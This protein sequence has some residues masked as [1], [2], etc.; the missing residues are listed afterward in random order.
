M[1]EILVSALALPRPAVPRGRLRELLR[2]LPGAAAGLAA[3][4]L[5]V[6]LAFCL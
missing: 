4:F 3:A 5:F 1:P 2:L 6:A